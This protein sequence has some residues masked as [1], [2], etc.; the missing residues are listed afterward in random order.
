[1]APHSATLQIPWKLTPPQ[2][3][4]ER[5]WEENCNS[6]NTR[7]RY[8]LWQAMTKITKFYCQIK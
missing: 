7:Q 4:A 3:E 6:L 1:M 2:I 5:T 8:V